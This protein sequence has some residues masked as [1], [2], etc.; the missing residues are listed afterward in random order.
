MRPVQLYS[1]SVQPTLGQAHLLLL[2]VVK[3][4]HW[5]LTHVIKLFVFKCMSL[6]LS[7]MI[8]CYVYQ[9]HCVLCDILSGL[10]F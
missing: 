8:S 4:A 3:A 1:L 9:W 5:A 2:P 10:P 6:D 7:F